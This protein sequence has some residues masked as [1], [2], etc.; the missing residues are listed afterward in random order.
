MKRKLSSIMLATALVVSL[1]AGAG[2]EDVQAAKKA[3]LGTK[4]ITLIRGKTKKIKV[5]NKKKGCR[6]TF[7][8]NKKKV[9][10]VTKAGKVK[11]VAAGT[12][13]ITV[14]EVSKRGKKRKIGVVKVLVKNGTQ[15]TAAPQPTEASKATEA[16]KTSE[17][18][19]ATNAPQTTTTPGK[20]NVT[21][22][23]KTTET[24]APSASATTAPQQ[25]QELTKGTKS[26]SVYL[27]EVSEAN[28]IAEVNGPGLDP[29]A[30]PTE[31]PAGE[32]TP[33]PTPAV[34]VNAD[35]ED[36]NTDPIEKRGNA[37][38][39]VVEDGAN[40]TSKSIKVTDRSEDWH[41][42]SIDV[43]SFAETDNDYEI[44]FYAKQ[45]TGENSK[46]DLSMQYVNGSGETRYDGIKTFDLPNDT[47]TKCEAKMTIPEHNGQIIIYWQSVYNSKNS[48]DFYLDEVSI[49]GVAK[50]VA[51]EDYPDLSLGLGKTTVGNPIMTSRL[52]ADPYAMEYNGRI[53]VYGTND[54]QQYEKT[55]DANNNYSKINTI[56]VYST[57]DMV[58]WTD[59]GAIPVAGSKGAAKWAS[60][61]WAPAV[62]HKT[63]NGKEKFFLYF[64]DNGSGIG[65]L[66]ADSPTGP[67]TD[68][69][70]KQ[71]I[72]R[73]TPGCSGSEIGWLFDPAVLVD[74]DGTGYLYFGG[75][76]D[77]TNKSDDFIAHPKCAR[78]VKLA[79]DMIS[80]AEDPV[81]ID[82]PYI[83]EDSGIN[84]I[85][86][87]YYYSYCTNWTSTSD[88]DVPIANIAVMVSDN[89]LTG[90]EYVGCVLK[91]PGTYFGA[92][93]NNHHCFA[94]FKGTWYAFYHTK[95]DTLALGTKGDYRTTY[96]D[97]LNLGDTGHFTNAD[98]SVAD[99]KMTAAGVAA[100]GT[101]N[102]YNTIEAESFAIANQVGTIANKEASSNA[103][104]NG[105]NYSLYNTEA[106]SY[107]GVANVDFGDGGASTVSMKLSD[108]SMTEYKECIAQ[109]SQKV[110]GKHT[111]Y[112]VFEK[113][114]ILMDSWKFDK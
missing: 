16:P 50:A 8:S 13:K 109:L 42:A 99:T 36:D 4:K 1:A 35:M 53:Y 9:A 38:I 6:Y 88:R 26:V 7:T 65:V 30:A 43:T 19:K 90:F 69:I 92:S 37:S 77:T 59:H 24:P 54:S 106:G 71:L 58:N 66:E 45:S 62:C 113:T 40:G 112:F 11:A 25:T 72:S 18:P 29:T 75:I 33:V 103:L 17:A 27:D 96:A 14:K 86:D 81:M 68:P 85:G 73:E 48:M 107:I 60:N 82:A 93:G 108:T 32:A 61:S 70:G 49:T 91:N 52:T 2:G 100:V 80:L 104:W 95:K 5:K 31:A 57:D 94:E 105:A 55:P 51:G 76:G 10:T 46:I 83:F 28:K 39:S 79:D 114:N 41:G 74:D 89:P 15:S 102:P 44:T 101:V 56:N 22:T 21:A 3:K 34:I 97:V 110:T 78:A 84:K 67:W 111:V 47:W 63:I 98:G 64:A 87:K 12:A 20:T 23:P